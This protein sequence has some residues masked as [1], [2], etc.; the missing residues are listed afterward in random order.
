L[1]HSGV[2]EQEFRDYNKKKALKRSFTN[3]L[4]SVISLS[5]L[6]NP[7]E[8]VAFILLAFSDLKAYR[9]T[10][11]LG[12]PTAIP[13]SAFV[14]TPTQLLRDSHFEN[15]CSMSIELHRLLLKKLDARTSVQHV[16]ALRAPS[17]AWTGDQSEH[18]M[19]HIQHA[20]LLSFEEAWAVRTDPAVHLVL[21][22][23]TA[24]ASGF[25]WTLRNLLTMLAVHASAEESTVRVIGL[26]GVVA[27]KICVALADNASETVVNQLLSFSDEN[28]SE[29][30][31]CITRL[32]MIVLTSFLYFLA[33]AS[34]ES[35]LSTFSISSIMVQPLVSQ[36]CSV[37]RVDSVDEAA[38]RY[39]PR[40]IRE[41]LLAV[42]DESPLSA[43]SVVGWETNERS[44]I[45]NH[46]YSA[47]FV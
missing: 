47:V 6:R 9:F 36:V 35:V 39:N 31:I 30:C 40:E 14:S 11:W 16:F 28:I 25:G 20:E 3:V 22:D 45:H 15:G 43:L 10:Y 33:V 44:V 17:N 34:D 38:Q 8:L 5:A 32:V 4:E 29:C 26:R 7:S 13:D 42:D 2:C 12:V 19:Q 21:L 41:K 37:L 46:L 24:D 1:I 23:S 27:K 18:Q